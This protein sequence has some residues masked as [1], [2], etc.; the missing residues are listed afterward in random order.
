MS[1]GLRPYD[2]VQQVYYA[3]EKVILDFWPDDDKYKEVLMEANLVLQELQNTE[4]WTW[5][6]EQLVLGACY[7]IPGT[8]KEFELPDWVYKLSTL[9]HDAVRLHWPRPFIHTNRHRWDRLKE[10]DEHRFINV[11]I[12]S[13]GDTRYRKEY[14]VD[15]FDVVHVPDVHLR[16]IK[17]GNILT[18]N[19]PLTPMEERLIAVA[20]VQRRIELFHICDHTCTG[21]N[22]DEPISY[23]FN[24]KGRWAN[25]CSKIER[26]MLTEIPDPNYVVMATAARHAEGSPPALAR[27][28]GLQDAAQRILSAMRQNDAAA[29]DADY[30]DWDTAGYIEVI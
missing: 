10:Y 11:P 5:L 13:S 23:E 24:D 7:S 3:Q 28:A 8:I 1:E 14:H 19:R 12:A 17:M 2:F 15:P 27:V 6:R 29:T 26:R 4:D 20:D 21:V 9:N 22:P 18:F 16:A 25:P 30:Q